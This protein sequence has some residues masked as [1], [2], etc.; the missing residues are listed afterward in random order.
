MLNVFWRALRAPSNSKRYINLACSLIL[1]ASNI[2]SAASGWGGWLRRVVW[3][4][5]RSEWHFH[6]RSC[7]WLLKFSVRRPNGRSNRRRLTDCCGD[8]SLLDSNFFWETLYW[9]FAVQSLHLNRRIL[10]QELINRKISSANSNLDIILL[11]LHSNLF[12]SKLVHAFRFSH[13][14]NL[15]ILPLW[16]IVDELGEASV[17]LVVFYWNIHRNPMLQ[18]NNILL[19]RFKFIFSALQLLQ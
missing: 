8:A 18:I 6:W 9:V 1:S 16:I 4:W 11:N 3:R 13:E 12:G 10:I 17:H 2:L 14:H 5:R 19:K 7:W 15:Q